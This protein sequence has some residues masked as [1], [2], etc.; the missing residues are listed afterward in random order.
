MANDYIEIVLAGI[1]SERLDANIV[2]CIYA[3]TDGEFAYLDNGVQSDVVTGI[4]YNGVLE[5]EN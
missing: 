5:L 1:P 4:S 3:V 2:F